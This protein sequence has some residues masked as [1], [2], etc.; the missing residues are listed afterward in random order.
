M[1][2]E[3]PTPE[4]VPQGQ[5]GI[6]PPEVVMFRPQLANLVKPGDGTVQLEFMISPLKVVVISIPEDSAKDLAAGIN[7]GI[8]VAQTMP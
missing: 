1:S 7:S 6:L 5:Q 2:A 4:A 8:H 3:A